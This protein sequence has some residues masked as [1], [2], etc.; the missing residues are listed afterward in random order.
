TPALGNLVAS[1]ANSSGTDAAGNA[2]I[3]ANGGGFTSYAS[4]G[5]IFYAILHAATAVYAF[6]APGAGGPW[7]QNG[8]LIGHN[9]PA[10]PATLPLQTVIGGV[11]PATSAALEVQGAINSVGGTVSSRTLITTDAWNDT[12]A[13]VNG[14]SKSGG[15]GYFKYRMGTNNTV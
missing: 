15:A 8:V 4:V 11:V 5:G 3:G 7:T 9:G 13:L 2:Y 10:N 14:W 6:S 12:P 1:I